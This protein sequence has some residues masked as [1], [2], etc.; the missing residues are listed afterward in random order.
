[1]IDYKICDWN[2][3]GAKRSQKGW[4]NQPT[5]QQ[6]K[7]Q[8][9]KEFREQGCM[10]WNLN[11][12]VLEYAPW[13][14]YDHQQHL[15]NS[16]IQTLHRVLICFMNH[17]NLFRSNCTRGRRYQEK[18]NFLLFNSL[19]PCKLF[20]ALSVEMGYWVHLSSWGLGRICNRW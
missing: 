13:P 6:A 11:L 20:L 12:L 3:D 14:L 18:E 7:A 19:L 9:N 1:M 17:D 8:T 5:S 16:K 15:V 10:L 4:E 2:L